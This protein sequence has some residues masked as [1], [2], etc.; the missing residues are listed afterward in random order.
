MFKITSNQS[1]IFNVI[2]P[3][4]K[5]LPSSLDEPGI[6]RRVIKYKR[7]IGQRKKAQAIKAHHHSN[8]KWNDEE[9]NMLLYALEVF[10]SH[11]KA[12]QLFLRTRS[13]QQIRSHVQKHFQ[14]V[15]RDAIKKLKRSKQL[16]GKVFLVTKQYINYPYRCVLTKNDIKEVAELK[17]KWFSLHEIKSNDSQRE[18]KIPMEILGGKLGI[19]LPPLGNLSHDDMKGEHLKDI[20]KME[21]TSPSGFS[22]FASMNHTFKSVSEEDKPIENPFNDFNINLDTPSPLDLNSPLGDMDD[23]SW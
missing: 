23:H 2:T 20:M 18:E 9:H 11:W 17:E 21:P 10:G 15:R 3:D 8:G 1:Q 22:C 14:S 7:S 5:I 13:A 12:I 4:G 16:K 19:D 6:R